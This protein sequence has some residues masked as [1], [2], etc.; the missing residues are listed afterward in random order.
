MPLSSRQKKEERSKGRNCRSRFFFRRPF[1]K[2]RTPFPFILFH[3]GASVHALTHTH[4]FRGRNA[5]VTGFLA[6][7][8]KL[9]ERRLFSFGVVLS[10]SGAQEKGREKKGGKPK[11]SCVCVVVAV[12]RRRRRLCR[13]SSVDPRPRNTPNQ[14]NKN[15][16]H[17]PAAPPAASARSCRIALR[18]LD[19]A[20]ATIHRA[21][22]RSMSHSR[23]RSDIARAARAASR[24]AVPN[25]GR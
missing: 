21:S 12:G 24:R 1:Q 3:L 4:T 25:I 10:S 17:L 16:N 19:G 5:S 9:R 13:S 2:K 8:C 22:D 20:T 18:T 23:G 7:S 6:R 11:T 15:P 14:K